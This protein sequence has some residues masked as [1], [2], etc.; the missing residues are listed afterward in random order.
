[1]KHRIKLTESDLHRIVKESVKR[2]LREANTELYGFKSLVF[3]KYT[4][5][6]GEIILGEPEIVD[7]RFDS[8]GM[9]L[10]DAKSL[11]NEEL[12]T[13][14]GWPTYAVL[15]NFKTGKTYPN[16]SYSNY[17]VDF[18]KKYKL[19]I[20]KNP[21][22]EFDENFWITTEKAPGSVWSVD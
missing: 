4:V 14:A 5:A 6:D 17:S 15:I 3:D 1:M 8:E 21:N 18:A 13:I 12:R 11:G 7:D 2:V 10:E 16:I 22:N 19:P 20:P 9:S